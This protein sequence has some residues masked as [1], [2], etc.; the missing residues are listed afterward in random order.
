MERRKDVWWTLRSSDN[1][2]SNQKLP[3]DSDKDR[4][5]DAE[6]QRNRGFRRGRARKRW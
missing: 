3:D 5:N 6:P 2:T 4:E 1:E